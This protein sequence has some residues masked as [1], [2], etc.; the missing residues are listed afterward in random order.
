MKLVSRGTSHKNFKFTFKLQKILRFFS[1]V[2]LFIIWESLSRLS[3]LD[4]RFFPPPTEL[5]QYLIVMLV[6]GTL[7]EAIKISLFR[8][9]IGYLSGAFFGIIIGLLLGLSSWMR[10]IFEPWLLMTYP[11]PKLALFPLLVLIVG[12]GEAPIII[13]LAIAVFYVVSINLIDGVLYIRRVFLDV[14]KDC[15]ANFRQIIFTIAIPSSL[16]H[17]ITGLEL[18]LGIAYIVLIAAE[19]VGAKSGLGSIIWSSWQLF[20]VSPMY[21]AIVTISILGYS[22]LLILRNLGNRLMPWR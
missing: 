13:L 18:S 3:Y 11:I 10:A 7:I 21:V 4:R 16:P 22:S 20:D 5:V 19:F 6:D 9:F 15:K 8:L 12:L 17:I 1:P 2:F 14:G